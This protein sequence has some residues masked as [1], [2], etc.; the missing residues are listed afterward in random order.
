MVEQV[1]PSYLWVLLFAPAM[2]GLVGWLIGRFK[3]QPGASPRWGVRAGS[4]SALALLGLLTVPYLSH[5]DRDTTAFGGVGTTNVVFS[6]SGPTLVTANGDSTWIL[7][8]ITDAA[9]PSRL[10][11]FNDDVRYSP[12]GRILASRNQLWSL[13]DPTHPVRAARFN[14]GEP[15]AFTVDGRTLA[16]HDR[17]STMLWN[18]SDVNHPRRIASVIVGEQALFSPDGTVL[19]TRDDHTA[20]VWSLTDPS[21]PF[22]VAHIPDAGDWV[23]SRDGRTLAISAWEHPVR[24]W[25]VSEPAHPVLTATLPDNHGDKLTFSPDSHVLASA[26]ADGGIWL[27]SVPDAQLLAALDAPGEF[28][29]QIGASDT[30]TTVA[31]TPDGHTLASVAGNVI[32]TRWDVTDPSAPVKRATLTRRSNGPGVVGFSPDTSIVAGAAIDRTNSITLW[33]VA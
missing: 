33:R 4:A 1:V 17:T 10:L 28:P 12:D 24:V 31:F 30:L 11:T 18:I 13:A 22:A 8:N 7:W 20:E 25:N 16:T 26:R 29:A 2:G 15:L 14:G 3:A 23:L 27:W 6:P 5:V 9:R 21:Q 32:Q 19:F